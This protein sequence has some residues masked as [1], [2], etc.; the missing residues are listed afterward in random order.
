M[1]SILTRETASFS[2]SRSVSKRGEN[3]PHFELLV[4]NNSF[5]RAASWHHSRFST[6]AWVFN[7]ST[8]WSHNPT[9]IASDVN[10]AEAER[11][12]R[13]A[14]GAGLF[15]R[16]STFARASAQ[17]SPVSEDAPRQPRA[18]AETTP[19][20][21]LRTYL[22]AGWDSERSLDDIWVYLWRA[23]GT[24]CRGTRTRSG[25]ASRSSWFDGDGARISIWMP[26]VSDDGTRPT[27]TRRLGAS[28][29]ELR[30]PTPRPDFDVNHTR[31]IMLGFGCFFRLTQIVSDTEIL[32]CSPLPH[33]NHRRTRT[34]YLEAMTE[35]ETDSM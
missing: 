10:L 24:L 22:F 13:L 21:R 23:S 2:I 16:A 6:H 19:S 14:A 29:G 25:L 1:T 31:V 27:R 7:L 12:R 35:T 26:C 8:H 18:R 3:Q 17:T 34:L 28:A 9:S 20:M 30:P 11:A 32:P 15:S 33:S 5:A 4:L